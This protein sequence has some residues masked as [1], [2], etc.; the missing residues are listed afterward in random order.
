MQAGAEKEIGNLRSELDETRELL[1]KAKF[2]VQTAREAHGAEGE[3][4][5]KERE[6]REALESDLADANKDRT[7]L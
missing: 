4:K 6:R 2:E 3:E 7:A 1:S 5:Q